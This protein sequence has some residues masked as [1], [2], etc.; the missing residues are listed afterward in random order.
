M[1]MSRKD[2]VAVAESVRITRETYPESDAALK[3]LTVYLCSDFA[4]ANSSFDPARFMAACEP[5]R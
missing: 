1:S 4:S 2:F 5:K 3:V